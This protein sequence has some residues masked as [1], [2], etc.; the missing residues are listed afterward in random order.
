MRSIKTAHSMPLPARGL[1]ARSR[2]PRPLVSAGPPCWAFCACRREP[3]SSRGRWR[4]PRQRR[5]PRGARDRTQRRA[6]HVRSGLRALRGIALDLV[7]VSGS[8]GSREA[9]H[10]IRATSAPRSASPAPRGARRRHRTARQRKFSEPCPESAISPGQSHV[11]IGG[12]VPEV[13]CAAGT[14]RQRNA[15]RVRQVLGCGR[16]RRANSIRRRRF[17][18]NARRGPRRAMRPFSSGPRLRATRASAKVSGESAPATASVC[19]PWPSAC[20]ASRGCDSN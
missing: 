4:Q 1:K 20:E 16:Y 15:A 8:R 3:P 19:R 14:R 9:A 2:E 13:L 10:R 5:P 17:P 12:R 18:P 11:K 6:R 7:E